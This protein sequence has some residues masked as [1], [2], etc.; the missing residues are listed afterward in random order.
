LNPSK[1]TEFNQIQ[2]INKHFKDIITRYNKKEQIIRSVNKIET[3]IDD[4]EY[5]QILPKINKV[6]NDN[7]I[8]GGNLIRFANIL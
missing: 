2:Y 4:E 5:D 3:S 7:M 1:L 8:D 6:I